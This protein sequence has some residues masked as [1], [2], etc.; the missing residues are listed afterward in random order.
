MIRKSGLEFWLRH[1]RDQ[2]VTSLGSHF[3]RPFLDNVS[4]GV[5]KLVLAAAGGNRPMIDFPDGA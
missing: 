3:T 1:V 5:D 4:R 2:H